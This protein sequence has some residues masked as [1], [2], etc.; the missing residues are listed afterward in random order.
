VKSSTIK[1]GLAFLLFLVACQARAWAQ[2]KPQLAPLTI[3]EHPECDPVF[4]FSPP[5]DLVGLD[6]SKAGASS[7]NDSQGTPSQAGASKPDA[8][9]PKAPALDPRVVSVLVTCFDALRQSIDE[10]ENTAAQNAVAA[11]TKVAP[12]KKDSTPP[13]QKDNTTPTDTPA[14]PQKDASANAGP[15]SKSAATNGPAPVAAISSAEDETHAALRKIYLSYRYSRKWWQRFDRLSGSLSDRSTVT[16]SYNALSEH[17]QQALSAHGLTQPFA[18]TLVTAFSIHDASASKGGAGSGPTPASTGTGNAATTTQSA[19]TGG[20]AAGFVAF[21]SAH[22]FSEPG[23]WWDVN[24]AGLLGFRPTLALVSASPAGSGQPS[25]SG[26]TSSSTAVIADYQQ[27]FVWGIWPEFNFRLAD[28]AEVT[29]FLGLGQT[30]L[31]S[32]Q[33]L[34]QQDGN[35]SIGTIATNQAS[36]GAVFSEAGVNL[37]IYAQ[38][39]EILHLSKGLITPM[40]GFDAGLR[41]DNRFPQEGILATAKSPTQRFFI[42]MATNAIPF[43]DASAA[44]SKT[45]TLTFSLEYEKPLRGSP[46]GVPSGTRVLI[47]GDLNLFKATQPAK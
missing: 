16:K 9:K 46:T 5:A 17:L 28:L 24:L 44:D 42:R 26:Q 15:A 45:L 29:P 35:T 2:I 40:F 11:T 14:A 41:H 34:V 12:A 18:A 33:S 22:F 19:G 1:T 38:S 8:S 39:L 30:I 36:K 10:A 43:Q 6:L 20:D 13:V 31:T 47:R 4:I 27:A 23:R 7:L 21:E 25:G 32:S 3:P 37:S